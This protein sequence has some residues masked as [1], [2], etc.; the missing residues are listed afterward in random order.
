MEK[1]VQAAV[2]IVVLLIV[3][4]GLLRIFY[5]RTNAVQK[6]GYGARTM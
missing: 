2:G 3:V 6:T 4:G 1:Y 5:A